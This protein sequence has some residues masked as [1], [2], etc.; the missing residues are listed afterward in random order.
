MPIPID[1]TERDARTYARGRGE[2]AQV[3]VLVPERPAAAA[4]GAGGVDRAAR[5]AAVFEEWTAVAE[6]IGEP[7]AARGDLARSERCL[8]HAEVRGDPRDVGRAHAH[9]A[10]RTRAAVARALAPERKGEGGVAHAR[11]RYHMG[12][13]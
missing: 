7:V 3:A 5:V 13:S 6:A 10:V 12:R 1:P 8:G 9:R 11:G 2:R 4:L